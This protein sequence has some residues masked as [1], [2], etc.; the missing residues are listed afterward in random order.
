[1]A[2]I[3][4]QTMGGYYKRTNEGQFS[5]GFVST[6]PVNFDIKNYVLS[7][8]RENLFDRNAIRDPLE[9]LEYFYETSLMC[10]PTNVTKG[11]VKSRLFGFSLIGREK[12]WLL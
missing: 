8:L 3:P 9:H 10:K 1:M 5:R 4:P 6:D 2:A 11:L 12:N 7:I